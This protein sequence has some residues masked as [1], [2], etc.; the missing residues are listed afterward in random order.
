MVAARTLRVRQRAAGRCEYCL[1]PQNATHIPFEIDHIISRKHDGR[2]ITSNLAVA[3][4][5]CDT[6]TFAKSYGAVRRSD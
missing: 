1:L 4:W 3:C 5:Y 2:T 6:H